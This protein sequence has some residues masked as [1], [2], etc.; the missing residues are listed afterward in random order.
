VTFITG[1]NFAGGF[2]SC[3]EP[4]DARWHP[5]VTPSEITLYIIRSQCTKF[6][7]LVHK[8][9]MKTIRA[10]TIMAIAKCL[11]SSLYNITSFHD[12]LFYQPQQ[13]Q[14]L[15][16]S[17]TEKFSFDLHSFLFYHRA[18]FHFSIIIRD[19]AITPA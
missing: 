4:W 1:F 2:Y 10:L 16:H 6:G 9:T 7:A 12:V 15:Y 17:Y 8:I 19:E 11:I 18:H 3:T 13:L 14:C 5:G